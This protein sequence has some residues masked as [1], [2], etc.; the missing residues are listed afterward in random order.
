MEL[1]D[2]PA[3]IIIPPGTSP[4]QRLRLPGRGIPQAQGLRGDAL[5]EVRLIMRDS[6]SQ[7]ERKTL[8]V[9]RKPANKLPDS[10]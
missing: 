4:G 7:E 9:L 6:L 2:G 1:I 10:V 8:E 5:A 3:T